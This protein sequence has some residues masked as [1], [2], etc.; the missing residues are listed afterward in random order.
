MMN[1][2]R[3]MENLQTEVLEIEFLEFSRGKMT[4]TETDFATILLRYT[5]ARP[6]DY[7]AYMD[8]VRQRIPDEK[9]SFR[10]GRVDGVGSSQLLLSRASRSSSSSNS[11]NS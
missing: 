3:F 9:V 4:I 7:K 10:R 6:D 2:F 11:A 5:V 1:L 8:R